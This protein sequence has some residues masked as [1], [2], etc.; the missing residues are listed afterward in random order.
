MTSE[1]FD[2]NW[3]RC[4]LICKPEQ[5]GKTFVMIKHIINDMNIKDDECRIINFILCDNSLLLTRQ[6][7]KRVNDEIKGYKLDG[8]TYLEFSSHARTICNSKDTVYSQI[9]NNNIDNIICCTNSSRVDDITELINDFNK[10]S[11]TQGKFIFKI[12]LDEADKYI[13]YIDGYFKRL[14]DKFDNVYMFCIT[15]TPEPIFKQYDYMN[16]L[17]IEN[18]VNNNY[19]GWKDNTLKLIDLNTNNISFIEHVLKNFQSNILP[20][21]KWFIPGLSKKESHHN[22]KDLCLEFNMAVIIINGDGLRLTLPDKEF[23]DYKKDDV[24][25]NMLTIIYKKHKLHKYPVALTG[26]LCIGRGITIMSNDF[27]IDY[28]I[29]SNYSNKNEIS[30]IAGRLKGNIKDLPNYKVPIIYTTEKFNKVAD[31]WEQKSRALGKIAHEM[32]AQ[33]LT[34]ILNFDEFNG[35]IENIMTVPLLLDAGDDYD[36]LTTK[37]KNKYNE[38]KIK[39]YI[40]SIYEKNIFLGYSKDQIS[41][42]QMDKS[43]TSYHK[44][45]VELTKAYYR[46]KKTCIAIKAKNRAKNVYQIWFDKQNKYII[47]SLYNG[48]NK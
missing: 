39:E 22:I 44:N 26:Y 32:V 47:I 14:I 27:I 3:M 19:H 40:N 18:P 28:A 41:E 4:T 48:A 29:L 13:N 33:E 31:E 20:G 10:G 45:I 38:T 42:P 17:P 15:A 1:D 46:N 37:N 35:I 9:M 7:S 25:N 34:P 24:F 11:L 30:Q 8:D 16:V 12:W 6:T 36:E 21:T 23:F 43:K 5:S 2:D